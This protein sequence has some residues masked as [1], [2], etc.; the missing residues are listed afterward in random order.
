[1]TVREQYNSINYLGMVFSDVEDQFNRMDYT[2]LLN[3]QIVELERDHKDFF[4]TQSGPDGKSWS[5]LAESTVKRKGHSRIL[6]L[7]GD[8]LA[9]LINSGDADAVRGVSERGLLFGTAV[10]YS[11]VHQ[12]G[13]SSG[14]FPARPHVGL[15][16]DRLDS[17]VESVADFIVEGLKLKA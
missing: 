17:M 5:P 11:M 13:P 4:E 7:T 15:T 8:L 9:S 14:K 1:M 16:A 10:E 3:K 2:K 12:E 6:F